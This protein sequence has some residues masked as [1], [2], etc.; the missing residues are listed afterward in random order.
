L[1]PGCPDCSSSLYETIPSLRKKGT[2]ITY[3]PDNP[4]QKF[5]SMLYKGKVSIII[6]KIS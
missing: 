4:I 1:K 6:C 2:Q 3:K 5:A